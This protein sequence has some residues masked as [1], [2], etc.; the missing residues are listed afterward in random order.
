MSRPLRRLTESGIAAYRE[1][2]AAG[3]SGDPPRYLL[4]QDGTSVPL[5]VPIQVQPRTFAS[6]FDLGQW[7]VQVLAPLEIR[8]LRFDRGLWNG[9]A[10]LLLDQLCPKDAAGVR[11][12]LK[13]RAKYD[14]SLDDYHKRARHLVRTPWWLVRE[15]RE[16][17]RFMLAGPVHEHG[18]LLEQLVNRQE[19][20]ASRPIIGAAASLY[21]DTSADRP[22][23]GATTRRRGGSVRRLVAVV[24]QLRLTYDMD[25][26]SPEQILQLLPKEFEAFQ[27]SPSPPPRRRLFDRIFGRAPPPPAG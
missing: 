21:W 26:M 22:K 9:L 7:L 24:K 6:K 4:E 27:R 14:L 23:P 19:I 20:A 17:A 1:W 12:I 16:A 3:G 11:R 18:E 25:A 5:E 2:I 8:T 15:H 13:D 10:L